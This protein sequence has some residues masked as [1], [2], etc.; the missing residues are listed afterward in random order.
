MLMQKSSSGKNHIS[1]VKYFNAQDAK[2]I[3]ADY[4]FPSL[5]IGRVLF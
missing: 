1:L 3:Y 4:I 5:S 2:L